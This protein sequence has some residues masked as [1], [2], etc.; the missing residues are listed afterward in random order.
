MK[1][2]KILTLVLLSTLLFTSCS[3]DKFSE[4]DRIGLEK[5]QKMELYKEYNQDLSNSIRLC[6]VDDSDE[7]LKELEMLEIKVDELVSEIDSLTELYNKE[8][9]RLGK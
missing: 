2:I 1:T 6:S 7:N 4:L 3:E 5:E 8:L 9:D